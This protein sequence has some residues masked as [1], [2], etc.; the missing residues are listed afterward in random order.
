MKSGTD[1]TG[2]AA[3]QA[4]P[5]VQCVANGRQGAHAVGVLAQHLALAQA[6]APALDTPAL[7]SHT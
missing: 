7:R 3:A 1:C 6:T 5:G 4:L 2:G